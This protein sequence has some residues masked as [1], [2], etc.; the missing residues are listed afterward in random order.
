M[1]DRKIEAPKN[2]WA[3][4]YAD[5]VTLLLTFFVLTLIIVNEAQSNIYRVIDVLLDETKKDIESYI[6]ESRLKN[7]I[8]VTRDTKGVKLLMSSSIVFNIN[9]AEIKNE[10]KPILRNIGYIIGQ[11]RLLNLD[12]YPELNRFERILKKEGINLDVE[13]RVEGH[14]D[15]LPIRSGKYKNN[16]ELST[17]RAL[18]VVKF[19]I[20]NT[21]IPEKYFSAM[22]Y[23][24]FRPIASNNTPT[25]RAKNRRVEI[26]VDA[27]LTRR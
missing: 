21:G 9:E 3:I 24:E 10:F 16:W 22:G 13:I 6:R 7:L 20:E 23:G 2:F 15:N 25:G 14:T 12:R 19:L 11:S 17:A 1:S 27:D 4:T 8:K 18:N 5:M 26:Y